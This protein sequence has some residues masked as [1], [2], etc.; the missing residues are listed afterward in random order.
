MELEELIEVFRLFVALCQE[1]S[2]RLEPTVVLLNERL[3]LL[4]REQR[5][6]ILLVQRLEEHHLRV[7][8]VLVV[9]DR[10]G[11]ESGFLRFVFLLL[12]RRQTA[13]RLDIDVYRMERKDRNGIVRIT[14]EV[15]M[16]ERGIVDR[17][18][19]DHLLAGSCSPV[20]HLL[21]IL[22]LTDTETFFRTQRED[23]NSHTRTFPTRLRAAETTVVLIDHTTL[24]DTPD[25]AVLTPL[26]I[27]NSTALEVVHH[28]FVLHD[29][30]AFDHDVCAPYGE[31]RIVHDEL[32]IY[33]PVA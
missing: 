12:R 30:L 29:V 18:R 31:V 23:R 4:G 11:I 13:H 7:I 1:S 21:E 24:L 16:T 27:H 10:Q 33:V 9:R 5:V 32:V 28:V 19:L 25:L 15:V 2:V 3:V 8:D 6:L 22:E 17:Q 14:V 26:G 20:C